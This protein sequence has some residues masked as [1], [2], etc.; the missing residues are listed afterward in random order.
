MPKNPGNTGHRGYK[1]VIVQS[2]DPDGDALKV[3]LS[4]GH[5]QRWYPMNNRT[6]EEY[7]ASLLS[8]INPFVPGQTKIRCNACA[9][10]KQQSASH[11]QKEAI[12]SEILSVILV[13]PDC[14]HRCFHEERGSL[15]IKEEDQQERC[16]ECLG[17]C[18]VASFSVLV[19]IHAHPP[20]T[21]RDADASSYETDHHWEEQR[22]LHR[23]DVQLY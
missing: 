20:K 22:A 9:D 17:I 18:L 19:P 7:R 15:V 13:C 11:R 1:M 8:G 4:C 14:G 3:T 5:T 6:V 10:G 12:L 23:D 2:F 21:S 16:S